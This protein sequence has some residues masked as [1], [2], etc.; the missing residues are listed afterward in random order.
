M[1]GDRKAKHRILKETQWRNGSNKNKWTLS[2]NGG[3]KT[4]WWLNHPFEKYARQGS[5]PQVGGKITNIWNHQL[6]KEVEQQPIYICLTPDLEEEI[7]WW[8]QQ[9]QIFYSR[10]KISGISHPPR[11]SHPMPH[12]Y[13]SICIE[14]TSKLILIHP[15]SYHFMFVS[16]TAH[17]PDNINLLQPPNQKESA[18]WTTWKTSVATLISINLKPL[19][20]S[21]LPLP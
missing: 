4:S 21:P 19:K 11:Q 12:P 13:D 9:F 15:I 7:Y 8:S 18:T 3:M 20:N 2:W 6:E 17:I 1:F 14:Y 16:N 10:W 5:F